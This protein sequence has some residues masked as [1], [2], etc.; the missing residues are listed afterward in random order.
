MIEKKKNKRKWSKRYKNAKFA[1]WNPWS[2]S[3][4][5]HEYCKSLDNDIM[6][7][8]ELHNNQ[9]KPQ[10]QGKNWICSDIAKE[11]GG[12]STDPA[13][14]VAILLS[15]RMARNVLSKGHVGARIV[16]VRLRGP[17]CNLFVVVVYVP[18]KGRQVTPT[19]SDIIQELNKLLMTV[20]KQDCIVLGGDF[21]CQLQRNVQ[22]CTGKWSMTKQADNG[23]GEEMIDLMRKHDLFATG[24]S[25]KPKKRRWGQN[26]RKRL[27][28]ASYIAKDET[29]R[30]RRLDYMCVSNRWRS[31]VKNVSVKWAPS[32][33]RFGR[34]FDHGLVSAI[35]HWRTRKTA[36]Y[37]TADYKA[38]NTQSWRRFDEVLQIKTQEKQETREKRGATSATTVESVTETHCVGK[39]YATLTENIRE[40]IKEVVPK[41]KNTFRNGR[42]VSEETKTLFKER[43]K[44]YSRSKPTSA[45]RK[46]WNGKIKNACK[47]DYRRWVSRWTERIE[48]A[49]AKGDL[50][51]VYQGVQAVSGTKRGFSDTQP[52]TLESRRLKNPEELANA[53][54]GFLE[55]KFAATELERA[56]A[57]FESL[58]NC[59]NDD[60]DITR[61]EFEFAVNKLKKNKSTGIDGVPAEVWQGS[62]VAK[63][64]LFL[65][66]RKIWKK[67]E[68]PVELSVG[69]FIMIFKNKGSSEDYSKYRCIGLLCH[70]Y[71]IMSV[72][73]L[74]RLIKEC[75][76]YFSDWQAGFRQKRGCRDNVLLLRVIYDQFIK[77]H[78][79]FVVTYIDFKAAFDSVSHKYIDS[80]LAKAG[81]S[82]KCRA[83]FRA[84]Y[85]A[86]EGTARVNGLNGEKVYSSRFKV[87]RGV[88]QGDII[89]PILFILALE[90]LIRQHDV[91]GD[92][93]RCGNLLNVRVLGYADD[94]ALLDRETDTMSLRLTTLG[95]AA[96]HEADM[97]ISMAKTY[98]QHVGRRSDISVTHEEVREAQKTFAHR[99]D[100]C[101][102]RFRSNRAM[103]I[104]RQS[105]VHQYNTTDEV[106]TVEDIVG[107]FGRIEARWM[108]VKWE[109]YEQPEWEREH[110]LRRDGCHAA[111]RSFWTRSGLS[112]DKKY[113][114]D[115][116]AHRCDVCARAYKR[117]Q[118]LK[119]HRTR[120]GHHFQQQQDKV[121]ATA[122]SAAKLKKRTDMQ[123]KLP[124]VRWG[125]LEADNC[126]RFKYLGSVFDAD[127][128]QM[129]DVQRRVAMATQRFGK[130]RHIWKSKSLHIRL[131]LRLYIASVCSV[132]T[133]G[134]EAWFITDAI[135]RKINGANSRMLSVITGKTIRQEAIE[136]SCTFN[137]VRAIRA[138]RLQWLGHILRLDEDRLLFKAIR[139]M[140]EGR[141]EGDLLMD[142]PVTKTWEELRHWA[143]DRKKWRSR[144]QAIRSGTRVRITKGVFVPESEFAFTIS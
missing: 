119:A 81:A 22:G 6:G 30:P 135:R 136:E 69:V 4:E 141:S 14:G 5:R 99:C 98:S 139:L 49:D 104:H 121:T 40:T 58:P 88:I 114:E 111:I 118:D 29:R 122:T 106:F 50:K 93:V 97:E 115:E 82:R 113:Y 20:P 74:Q 125:D 86:A 21:N 80:A 15:Q 79:N 55:N 94:A 116:S 126:W 51:A 25:F 31:M 85:R 52:T 7:L 84:I 60:D 137:L 62:A 109:G 138:R 3:N 27:C 48:Q 56:R 66:L 28:N 23:H 8:T 78:R 37:E 131:R 76:G 100:F 24:T 33:H 2:Y 54:C 101:D 10:F 26:K 34:R 9:T 47:N 63:E 123:D 140:Y 35:W 42:S 130:M 91:H 103:L 39:E 90:Q 73:L 117:K 19:A 59:E 127:G 77:E 71:K 144:V 124:K 1:F 87:A 64:R 132:M 41:K 107:V 12:K 108:L 120:T 75:S 68:V 44:E 134:S 53:W 13:A 105:C 92:G 89:S 95:D 32:T 112:P 67:E 11:E 45:R 16:W 46:E 142:A 110:L 38:M 70:A 129:A 43:T 36:K 61:K 128:G 18:H 83:I 57:E 65:F 96:K 17:I 133:Y 102:R 143:R 72:I